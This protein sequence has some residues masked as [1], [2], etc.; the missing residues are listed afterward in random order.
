MSMSFAVAMT[1]H[2]R[3]SSKRRKSCGSL[4]GGLSPWSPGPI[5]LVLRQGRVEPVVGR[6]AG[7]LMVTKKPGK[8]QGKRNGWEQDEFL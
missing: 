1:K 3:N 7:H 6:K 2:L 4:F 8:R 5:T